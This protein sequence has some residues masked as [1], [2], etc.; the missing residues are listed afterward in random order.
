MKDHAQVG[1][2]AMREEGDEWRAYYA[3]PDTMKGALFLGSIKLKFV[4]RP[5]RKKAFMDLMREA[6]AD[7]IESQI[8]IR[9][10]WG[11]EK[12]APFWERGR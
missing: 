6:V 7:I 12:V 2:L 10:V 8:G 9:P 3:L 1:R 11:G 4:E 5:E